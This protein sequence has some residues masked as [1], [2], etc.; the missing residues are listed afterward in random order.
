MENKDYRAVIGSRKAP[1]ENALARHCGLATNYHGLTHPSLPNYLGATGGATFG[2]TDD[3]GPPAH[4]LGGDSLFGQLARKRLSWRAYEESMPRPC[5][6]AP[7]GSYAVKHNPAAYFT[8]IRSACRHDD[9]PLGGH[10]AKALS[11]G[12]LPAF[13]FITPNLCHD[14]HDC[15]VAVGDAWLKKWVGRI[16]RSRDYRAGRTLVVVTWDEGVGRSNRIPTLV[17]GAS[18]PAGARSGRRL[19]HYSLLRATEDVLGLAHLRN[20]RTAHSM[21]AAFRL[22]G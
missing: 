1:Y 4:R 13:S 17:L 16:V 8:R 10:L 3:A 20:A 15:S 9:L 5:A 19:N 22:V 18:V 7:A 12:H 2:V 6:A 21:A 14:T 11:S